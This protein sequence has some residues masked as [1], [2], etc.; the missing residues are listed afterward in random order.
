MQHGLTV[1]DL[2]ATHL[3]G[4][5]AGRCRCGCACLL[6]A[7]TD[8]PESR[9]IPAGRLL[10]ALTAR[11]GVACCQQLPLP[12]KQQPECQRESEWGW[13]G[14]WG[15]W[16]VGGSRG[17]SRRSRFPSTWTCWKY[18]NF[19]HFWSFLYEELYKENTRNL[20]IFIFKLQEIKLHQPWHVWLETELKHCNSPVAHFIRLAS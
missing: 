18:G 12:I 13:G 5:A 15:V 16:G 9:A 11:Q 7:A 3:A 19:E 20:V 6:K 17:W 10:T 2:W 1:R 8:R 14:Q 4:E